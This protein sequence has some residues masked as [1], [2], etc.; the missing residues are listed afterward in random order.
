[1]WISYQPPSDLPLLPLV[2]EKDGRVGV[3][4]CD[5]ARLSG[6]II[7]WCLVHLPRVVARL[8]GAGWL[9]WSGGSPLAAGPAGKAAAGCT[10]CA[11]AN[12]H[13]VSPWGPPKYLYVQPQ[14]SYAAHV[15]CLCFSLISP[16]VSPPPP[17]LT[18][19]DQMRS[20]TSCT[21]WITT[22]RPFCWDSSWASM[23]CAPATS[24]GTVPGPSPSPR[25]ATLARCWR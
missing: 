13:Q 10:G 21:P 9:H 12:N 19:R 11:C 14:A 20:S 24:T 3:E 15:V 17:L 8:S 22:T 4:C 25:E 23:R 2:L 18:P 7:M 5:V 16:V 1:M 6:G